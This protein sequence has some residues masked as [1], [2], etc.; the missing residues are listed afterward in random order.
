MRVAPRAPTGTVAIVDIDARSL[1][2]IGLWPWPRSVHATIVDRLVDLGA[3]NIAFDVD[4]SSASN[5]SDDSA[6]EDALK[7]AGGSVALASFRQNATALGEAVFTAP[8]PRFAQ[9]AWP[10]IINVVP[11][12]DGRVRSLPYG[13][14]VGG[15][16]VPSLASLL[17]GGSGALGRD[18]LV[19][20]SIA[21]DRIDRVSAIDVI[22]GTVNPD[23]IAGKTLIVGATAIELRDFFYVPVDGI[24]SGALLQALG[25]ESIL[26][27]R[28]LARSGDTAAFFLGL[29]VLA[30]AAILRLRW[31]SMLAVLAGLG[32]GVELAAAVLQAL[33]PLA[34]STAPLLAMLA[35]LAVAIVIRE[36]NTRAARIAYLARF[37]PLTGVANRN[38]FLERLERVEG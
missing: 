3:A 17:A 23:R 24:V 14:A 34:L 26:E 5:E 16:P 9:N 29:L 6:F 1:A 25:V 10:A 33:A 22:E 15:E 27:G 7:R 4:F 13:I 31:T 28:T 38:Q 32:F 37:D 18:F 20:F 8:L 30:G 2:A 12:A 21:A 36:I 19:D 11:D 35:L